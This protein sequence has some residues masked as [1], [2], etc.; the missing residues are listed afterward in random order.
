MKIKVGDQKQ[1][2]LAKAL[3]Y[4]SN[5]LK[6][7][8]SSK[9]FPP[10]SPKSQNLSGLIT[11]SSQ[12]EYGKL[13]I[14]YYI[15]ESN[16]NDNVEIAIDAITQTNS[17]LSKAVGH[18]HI[19]LLKKAIARQA[20]KNG[21]FGDKLALFKVLQVVIESYRYLEL[22][23][24]KPTAL[25][26]PTKADWNKAIAALTTLIKAIRNGVP[27]ELASIESGMTD[28]DKAKLSKLKATMLAISEKSE[29]PHSDKYAIQRAAC[30][31]FTYN[32][33]FFF[34]RAVPP[35]LVEIFGDIIG[36]SSKKLTRTYTK[37]W[38]RNLD[39]LM[40]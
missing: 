8:E 26:Q 7:L 16:W 17:L 32:L 37:K 33:Y 25:K 36:Y 22:L 29:K 12:A 24:Q 34:D 30:Q 35:R 1:K 40:K 38:V 27:V 13:C 39:R 5:I 9:P 11:L 20:I 3:S 4:I 15:A 6:S 14:E 23:K 28:F 21:P 10:T 31:N 18:K 2:E 19:N